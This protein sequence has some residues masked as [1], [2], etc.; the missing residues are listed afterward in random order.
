[1][2]IATILNARKLVV[3]VTGTAKAAAMRA[4]VLGP[5]TEAVPAS[6]LHLHPNV[7]V[8]ADQ[9]AASDVSAHRQRA[10]T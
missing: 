9:A 8:V 6:V 5:V 3:L 10:L 7:L 2:G 1:M 4:T